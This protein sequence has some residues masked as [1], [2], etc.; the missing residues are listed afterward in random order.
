MNGSRDRTRESLIFRYI[1][2]FVIFLTIILGITFI[3]AFGFV[4]YL[5]KNQ[6]IFEVRS[7]KMIFQGIVIIFY[8]LIFGYFLLKVSSILNYVEEKNKYLV[9]EEAINSKR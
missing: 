6:Q 3:V 1:A 8:G 5:N 9:K 4:N 2:I 7:G